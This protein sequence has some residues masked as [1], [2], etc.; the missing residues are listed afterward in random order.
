[1]YNLKNTSDNLSIQFMTIILISL[2]VFVIYIIKDYYNSSNDNQYSKLSN[3]IFKKYKKNDKEYDNM[4]DETT[5]DI[6]NYNVHIFKK[7]NNDDLYIRKI[8]KKNDEII[9]GLIKKNKNSVKLNREIIKNNHKKDQKNRMVEIVEG[10]SLLSNLEDK[11]NI[12]T[13]NPENNDLMNENKKNST[14]NSDLDNLYD[15]IKDNSVDSSEDKL[16]GGDKNNT[17][18]SYSKNLTEKI[19]NNTMVSYS[20]N[21]TEELE[22]KIKDSKENIEIPNISAYSNNLDSKLHILNKHVYE[23]KNMS[24]N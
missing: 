12:A 17:V 20:D 3:L 1:M 18:E 8:K 9:S 21:L 13:N 22:N 19:E 24:N 14:I 16:S 6:L 4:Y 23:L 10:I 15:E 5:N 11:S 7:K 2:L